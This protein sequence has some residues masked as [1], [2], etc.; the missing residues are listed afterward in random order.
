MASRHGDDI[1]VPPE[2]EFVFA[3]RLPLATSYANWLSGAAIERG[4]IGPREAD[5]LWSRHL[6][7]CAALT[8]LIPAGSRMVDIGSGAG[9]PGLVIAIARPDVEVICVDSML[10]R[11]AFLEE[12]IGD[13]GLTNVQ[14]RRA[15][16]EDLGKR[17]VIGGVIKADVVTARAVGSVERLAQWAGPLLTRQGALLALKG[18]AVTEEL[19]AA[20]PILRRIGF[21]GPA[22]LFEVDV[23]PA[24]DMSVEIA[25]DMPAQGVPAHDD[26]PTASTAGRFTVMRTARWLADSIGPVSVQE[27]DGAMEPP[28]VDA[29]TTQSASTP[30]ATV[31][32]ILRS[33]LSNSATE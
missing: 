19:S 23:A 1:A 13:L 10:R 16:A 11:I 4:L 12:V 9:L 32:R 24:G 30:T 28:T 14:I 5:R 3:D 22:E 8:A 31:L 2:A 25:A 21:G 33:P 27:Q 15:R 17:G 29:G 26:A 20:W 18:S 6:L 7:N